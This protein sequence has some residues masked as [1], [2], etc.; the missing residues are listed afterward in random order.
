MTSSAPAA[1]KVAAFLYA[2]HTCPATIPANTTL[3]VDLFDCKQTKGR[4][5]YF[6][7]AYEDWRPDAKDFPKA[8]L[9][10]PIDGWAGESWV[11]YRSA[12]IRLIM[13]KRMDLAKKNGC[14]GVDPDNVDGVGGR[15]GFPLTQRE[16]L[17]FVQ[18]IAVEAH[19]RGLLVGLKNSAEIAGKLSSLFDYNVAEECTKYKECDRYPKDK[20]FFIEY[21]KRSDAVC[22][23]RPYT[24]FADTAL[25][26]FEVCK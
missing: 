23:A 1:F 10:K 11:D 9:G 21:M 22:K 18:F 4:I 26:K 15:T 8:T 19:K 13:S 14:L 16:Q 2:L 25:K 12:A 6:S 7:T 24:L 17:D 3:V 5:C 20:T